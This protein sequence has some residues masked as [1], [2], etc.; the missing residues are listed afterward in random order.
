[1]PQKIVDTNGLQQAESSILH[2]TTADKAFRR[3]PS[4]SNRNASG[5]KKSSLCGNATRW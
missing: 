3:P 2:T 1:M 4:L 5:Q